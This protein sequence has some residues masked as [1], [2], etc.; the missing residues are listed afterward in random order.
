MVIFEKAGQ[1]GCGRG[2]KSLIGV[3]PDAD[4]SAGVAGSDLEAEPVGG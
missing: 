2:S 1:L 4:V 3:T